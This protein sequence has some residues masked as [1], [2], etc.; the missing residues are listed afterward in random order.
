[1]SRRTIGICS[2]DHR[3]SAS[4]VIAY[5]TYTTAF[6]GVF[7]PANVSRGFPI[8]FNTIAFRLI[9]ADRLHSKHNATRIFNGAQARSYPAQPSRTLFLEFRPLSLLN[10]SIFRW[11]TSP[12]HLIKPFLYQQASPT[13]APIVPTRLN[14]Q[15]LVVL[16]GMPKLCLK[17]ISYYI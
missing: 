13:H 14:P 8:S 4:L 17:L 5:Y 2:N 7:K 6:P 16:T 9:S 12:S 15:L 1:M 3:L 11:H 10:P